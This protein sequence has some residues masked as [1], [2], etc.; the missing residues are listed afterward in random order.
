MPGAN[1]GYHALH[2]AKLVGDAG[3]VEMFEPLPYLADA[4]EASI[5]EN[6]FGAR[7]QHAT[8]RFG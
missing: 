8:H 2:L 1:I 3:F 4:L 7:T 6:G 5:A